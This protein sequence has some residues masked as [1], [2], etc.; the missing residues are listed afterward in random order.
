MERLHR[1]PTGER[2]RLRADASITLDADCVRYENCTS[3]YCK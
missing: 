2:V 3:G 1:A